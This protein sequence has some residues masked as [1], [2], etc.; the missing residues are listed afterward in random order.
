MKI[1]QLIVLEISLILMITILVIYLLRFLDKNT[2]IYIIPDK[3]PTDEP[4]N[5]LARYKRRNFDPTLKKY[6][7]RVLRK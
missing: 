4:L 2:R 5:S 7:K 6:K 1:W 3:I